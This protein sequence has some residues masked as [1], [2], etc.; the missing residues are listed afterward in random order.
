MNIFITTDTATIPQTI[1]AAMEQVLL[2]ASAKLARSCNSKYLILQ[3]RLLPGTIDIE[4]VVRNMTV[5]AFR[6]LANI[7]DR[8]ATNMAATKAALN[9]E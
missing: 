4:T 6:V 9:S 3:Y 8:N 5:G 7:S 1:P 2:N